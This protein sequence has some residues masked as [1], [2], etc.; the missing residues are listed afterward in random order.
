[1]SGIEE[2][3]HLLISILSSVLSNSTRQYQR[4]PS[5]IVPPSSTDVPTTH[6][7]DRLVPVVGARGG[8]G[9]YST[10]LHVLTR[11][12]SIPLFLSRSLLLRVRCEF[13][14]SVS[15]LRGSDPPLA[16]IH[17]VLHGRKQARL[18]YNEGRKLL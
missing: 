4:P 17:G 8:G 13:S 5:R 12:P 1:M 7:L 14:I 18:H 16:T 3:S 15:S 11:P 9:N 2:R 6:G 10:W